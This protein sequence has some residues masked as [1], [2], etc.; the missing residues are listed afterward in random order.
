LPKENISKQILVVSEKGLGKRTPFL[1]PVSGESGAEENT[2]WIK[3]KDE[4][5][6]EQAYELAYRVTNRGGKG[7]KTI[8]VTEKT[9]ALV[10]LLAVEENDDLMIT[11][12]SGLT[13]RMNVHNIREAGRATQGV[14]LINI[15]ANDEIA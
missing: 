1:L 6:N 4:E 12:K 13:I 10:G 14:R 7:V 2:K 11:C 15:D 5:G 3:I 8:N 9:G